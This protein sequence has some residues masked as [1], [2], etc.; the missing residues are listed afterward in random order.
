M[1]VNW[2]ELGNML[3]CPNDQGPLDFSSLEYRC[4]LCSA[5]F[6]ILFEHIADLRPQSPM[7][8]PLETNPEFAAGYVD[9]F[10]RTCEWNS[11]ALGFGAREVIPSYLARRKEREVLHV[12]K[13]LQA[14]DEI[15]LRTFCDFSAGAGY[16]TLGLA[17]SFPLVLHC[18]LSCDSLLYALLKA[19]KLGID[20]I[21]FL[22]IDYLR[23]PFASTLD[24]V[25]CMDSLERG[26]GHERMLLNAI[27]ESLRSDGMGVI[28]FHNWWHNPLRR[29]GL[30]PE[31]YRLN[32]SY[33]RCE[34][35]SLVR[36]CGVKNLQYW[37]F[38]Q[39][40]EPD[41]SK[42]RVAKTMVPPTRHVFLFK[43][44]RSEQLEG[45]SF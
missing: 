7:Q 6:P 19:Q 9:L 29:L 2:R 5:C 30:L 15:G 21:A 45:C 38:H 13:V 33:S 27:R 32:R 35:E 25:I 12:Q 40:F 36:C 23:P 22:R 14:Q 18:D 42:R 20:N 44:T 39:E 34:A 41:D 11:N 17:S 10:H 4:T 1:P 26:E 3:C 43:K 37:P 31:N 28:D 16:Y 8:L 24:C